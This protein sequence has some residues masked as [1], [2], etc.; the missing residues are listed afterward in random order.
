MAQEIPLLQFTPGN[1]SAV[2]G[3]RVQHRVP[4]Y[5]GTGGMHTRARVGVPTPRVPL[6]AGPV[7]TPDAWV[8]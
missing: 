3:S 4:G 5:P 2:P 1:R 8:P 7:C 6:P